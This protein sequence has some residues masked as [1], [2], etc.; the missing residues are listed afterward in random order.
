[1]VLL[2]AGNPAPPRSFKVLGVEGLGDC[3]CWGCNWCKVFIH[4]RFLKPRKLFLE[5]VVRSPK[6]CCLWFG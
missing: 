2:M 6:N 1:M 4:Q 3:S 5:A